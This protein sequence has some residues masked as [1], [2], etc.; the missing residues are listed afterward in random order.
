MFRQF[1]YIQQL[2]GGFQ[3][4]YDSLKFQNSEEFKIFLMRLH[5]FKIKQSKFKKKLNIER[6]IFNNFQ[7]ETLI[8]SRSYVPLQ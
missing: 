3:N 2:F 7:I 6:F 8:N 1:A 4:R 5:N